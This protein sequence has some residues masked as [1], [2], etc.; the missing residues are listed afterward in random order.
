MAWHGQPLRDG[1]AIAD[2][3]QSERPI[4][5]E[6]KKWERNG[7][8]VVYPHERLCKLICAVRLGDAIL[9]SDSEHLSK[10]GAELL[11]PQLAHYLSEK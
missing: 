7:V 11:L 10:K 6:L 3:L 4:L 9:Y 1:P 8:P 2:F 5:V